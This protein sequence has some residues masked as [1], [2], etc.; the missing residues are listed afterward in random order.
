MAK[1]SPSPGKDTVTFDTELELFEQI[2]SLAETVR[3]EIPE[4]SDLF[5]YRNHFDQAYHFFEKLYSMNQSLLETLQEKNASLVS[6]TAKTATI[7][8]AVQSDADTIE[9]YKKE[10][11]NVTQRLKILQ[12]SEE[13]SREVLRK[14][15]DTV[16]TLSEQVQRGEAFSYGE[17]NSFGSITQDVDNLTQERDRGTRTIEEVTNE[18]EK[19][20][21]ASNRDK[22]AISKLASSAELLNQ[23][24][25]ECQVQLESLEAE[26]EATREELAEVRPVVSA[27]R[28]KFE[29]NK[30]LSKEL[31]GRV[32]QMKVTSYDTGKQL[33]AATSTMKAMRATVAQ[34]EKT[35]DR[36]TERTE[37]LNGHC[38][39]IEDSMTE[40]ETERK[41]LHDEGVAI[42]K[43]ME[44]SV[45]QLE[46]LDDEITELEKARAAG[47]ADYKGR[48][49][50]ALRLR[51][52][53][54]KQA[55]ERARIARTI[56]AAAKDQ[57]KLQMGLREE[58]Q[59]T[60]QARQIRKEL[61]RAK[62]TQKRAMQGQKEMLRTLEQDIQQQ[63]T[64]TSKVHA[65]RLM[66]LDGKRVMD[67]KNVDDNKWLRTL[68]EKD[69]RQVALSEGLRDERNISKRKYEACMKEQHD[70]KNDVSDLSQE[71]K[72]LRQRIRSTEVDIAEKHFKLVEIIL[73]NMDL[74]NNVEQL[75][76]LLVNANRSICGLMAEE[77]LLKTVLNEAA[78]DKTKQTKEYDSA[79]AAR[80]AI[81]GALGE[82]KA[83]IED[84]R[85]QILVLKMHVDKRRSDYKEKCEEIARLNTEATAL[86][87]RNMELE[88]L[89]Q[90]KTY[91]EIESQKLSESLLHES[92]KN[93]ALIHEINCPRNVHRWK[94]YSATDE[95]Y[96]RNIQYLSQLYGKLHQAHCELTSLQEEKAS[97]QDQLK[98]KRGT[99]E[100]VD[101]GSFEALLS[102]YR[103]DISQKEKIIEE[104]KTQ[105][106]D[107]RDQSSKLQEAA[108]K[109]RGCVSTRR[110]VTSQLRSRNISSR[111]QQRQP[112]LFMTEPTTRVIGGGFVQ[113]P[114]KQVSDLE[115]LFGHSSSPKTNRRHYTRVPTPISPQNGRS[116]RP[117]TALVIK[118]TPLVTT[119]LA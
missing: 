79:V 51:R 40:A 17:E 119:V 20:R 113:K 31:T 61:S 80:S 29:R 107:Y 108:D 63:R 75:E 95:T 54:V 118:R 111:G 91:K 57:E 76:Q 72:E 112:L 52:E 96:T 15:N 1:P 89:K 46:K 4:D 67:E 43:S 2:K 30:E 73:K 64:D 11:E 32:R 45:V 105:A 10:Y 26:N 100:P 39:R 90:R 16:T 58:L 117:Q 97:L 66:T 49:D 114:G 62:K 21:E 8:R 92:V 14:L 5:R 56:N 59:E 38:D 68:Q 116:R 13:R 85:G 55:H 37:R 19:Y 65:K 103:K 47:R 86:I 98:A 83:A 50:E 109:L 28:K 33:V 84:L 94:M 3:S 82:R 35:L 18:I 53:H 22:E 93:S 34:K 104:L 48:M 81:A 23:K 12:D 74:E 88:Q 106:D 25:A 87:Q 70:L 6:A 60:E 77:Q 36:L 110:R 99:L 44:T 101:D 71:S 102:T 41:N 69:K 9:K 7:Y 42:D 78:S 115:E 27:N 24:I